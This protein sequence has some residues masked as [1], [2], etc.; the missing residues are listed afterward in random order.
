MKLIIG[1]GNPGKQYEKTRHNVG[2][3][4]LDKLASE[5]NFSDFKL[6]TKFKGEISEGRFE[7]EKTILIKPT[8]FMN[9]SG[10]SLRKIV[11]FYKIDLEDIIVI[12][13]DKD[14]DFGKIRFRETGS[15]GGH[16]GIKSIILHFGKDFKR[17]K[18]GIGYD[19]KYDVSDWVLGKF[20]E[21]NLDD[22]NNEIYDKSIELLKEKS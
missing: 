8:T 12:Y 20:S 21:D 7:G 22:I 19:N 2:F 4:F 10:E 9:L 3:I 1:L 13:D 6:E 18:I 14:M 11:D 17:I 15:A 5:N 16:N